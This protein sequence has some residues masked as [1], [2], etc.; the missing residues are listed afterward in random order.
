MAAIQ[1]EC[2]PG[3]IV[4]GRQGHDVT[5][6]VIV[7]SGAVEKWVRPADKAPAK[8]VGSLRRGASL[9]SEALAGGGVYTGTYRTTIPT[10]ILYLTLEECN[11][12][13]R[14]GVRLAT[15]VG[16]VLAIRQL[17]GRMPLFA[18]MGPQ[19]LDALAHKIGRQDVA[20]GQDII[21]QG[22]ER[23]HFYIIANGSVE[24]RVD[25]EPD[26]QGEQEQVVAQLGPGQHFGE[27]ALYSDEPYS[28]TCRAITPTVLLT[29][30]EA[31]FDEM[32][33][34][35]LQMTHYVEQ[36][37]SGRTIDTRRKLGLT[38]VM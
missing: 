32:V 4:L 12:L 2:V 19:Q 3:G 9:G 22:E 23:H 11:N 33:G 25:A 28:A 17:L 30:D 34:S 1:S 26:E 24:V 14:A 20:A 38:G 29:L 10:E 16:Q 31:T 36:V 13:M 7:Q 18:S 6:F 21:R 27:T 15:E 37:S 35:S 5:R 8:L